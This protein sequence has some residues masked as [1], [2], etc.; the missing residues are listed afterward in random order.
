MRYVECIEDFVQVESIDAR[1][2]LPNSAVISIVLNLGGHVIK[3]DVPRLSIEVSKC[4]LTSVV[5]GLSEAV[6]TEATK[7]IVKFLSDLSKSVPSA[8]GYKEHVLAGAWIASYPLFA[9]LVF[10]TFNTY[11]IDGKL[12]VGGFTNE[13]DI[14]Q[15]S[16]TRLRLSGATPNTTPSLVGELLTSETKQLINN[17]PI[18]LVV[19]KYNQ[20]VSKEVSM[21]VL[22]NAFGEKFADTTI[23][24]LK[25][26]NTVIA[27]GP[28]AG[29]LRG[30]D[31][32]LV[33]NPVMDILSKMLERANT[34][35]RTLGIDAETEAHQYP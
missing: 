17:K 7:A 9:R 5:K 15:V 1:Q 12:V 3:T 4:S 26:G 34:A 20:K 30:R 25:L 19:I 13:L 29:H 22:S 32:I 10:S 16:P 21:K 6:L 35:I 27:A 14:L 28:P 2:K 8:R 24:T 11:W 31:Y 23:A 33:V 18:G